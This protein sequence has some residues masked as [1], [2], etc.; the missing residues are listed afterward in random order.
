MTDFF[1]WL[2]ASDSGLG[3]DRLAGAF[4]LSH[5]E[6]RKTADALAPA[7]A[8][9]LQRMMVDPAAWSELSQR[10][11]PFMRGA[12]PATAPETARSPAAK[13]LAG[14][15]FGSQDIVAAVARQVSLI[16]GVAPDM[17]EQLM[18]NLSI[19]TIETMLKMMLTNM[20][21]NQPAG[22]AEGNLPAL[23]AEMMRRSAN[24]V[25]AMGRPSDQ[26]RPRPSGAPQMP[27]ADYLQKLFSDAL[28]GSVPWLP[29]EARPAQA[30]RAATA[31]AGDASAAA[32]LPGF[33]E[34]DAMTRAFL[35]G[36]D[37]PDAGRAEGPAAA[38]SGI[39]AETGAPPKPASGEPSQAEAKPRTAEAPDFARASLAL[40]EEYARQM[41]AIFGRQPLDDRKR[42]DG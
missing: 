28:N 5:Q 7:F 26:P 10:F 42:E 19:M 30:G 25:E 14:T 4:N 2:T 33:A 12:F 13:D 18:R 3:A 31:G 40:Q 27:G 41:M 24:A 38:S 11:L 15:L 16:I 36:W 39:R 32:G 29:P 35:R 22:L 20:A 17:V 23:M 1:D 6:M 9:A 8:L 37:S 21:R 34:W